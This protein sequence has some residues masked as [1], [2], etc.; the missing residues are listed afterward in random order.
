MS[1]DAGRLLIFRVHGV[2]Y[3]LDLHDV[4]EVLETFTLHPIPRA[5]AALGGA[6]NSHGILTP[7]VDLGSYFGTGPLDGEGTLLVL[8]RGRANC[9][10]L[11]ERVETVVPFDRVMGADQSAEP[12]FSR[13]LLLADGPVRQLSLDGVVDGVAKVLQA[14]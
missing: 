7:V 9:A 1:E 2:R 5:P 11:A 3:G 8:D 14:C 6:V 12:E 4:S 10:L 13:L